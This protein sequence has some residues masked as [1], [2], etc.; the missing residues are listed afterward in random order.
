MKADHSSSEVPFRQK[1]S[2]NQSDI[3]E[4]GRLKRRSGVVPLNFEA[5]G[6]KPTVGGRQGLELEMSSLS[7]T[8]C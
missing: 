5:E 7:T 3:A 6:N 8:H 4:E 2:D 1:S